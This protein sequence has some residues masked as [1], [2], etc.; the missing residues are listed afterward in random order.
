MLL[1]CLIAKHD[2]VHFVGEISKKMRAAFPISDMGP[3]EDSAFG[4]DGD[5]FF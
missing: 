1:I 5:E 4:R 3:D 2:K